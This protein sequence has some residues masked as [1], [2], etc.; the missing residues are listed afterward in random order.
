MLEVVVNRL[1]GLNLPR[2]SV[3]RLAN[4]PDLTLGVYRG[5]N[6][7][8]KMCYFPPFSRDRGEGDRVRAT[9]ERIE[10]LSKMLTER[11]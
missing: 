11:S 8:T 3:G 7:T 1:G 9:H 6:T 10:L 5:R 2:K 4:R